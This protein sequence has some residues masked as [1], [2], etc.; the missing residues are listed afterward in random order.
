[1]TLAT[2]MAPTAI[3][4]LDDVFSIQT[5]VLLT[6]ASFVCWFCLFQILKHGFTAFAEYFFTRPIPTDKVW[7]PSALPHPNPPG[8]AVPFGIR[9]V[10]ASEEQIFRFM[11]F[12]GQDISVADLQE[13]ATASA[14]YKGKLYESKVLE[15]IDQHF[16]LKLP[17]LSYPYVAP[18]FNGFA[19]FWLE[20]GHHLRKMFV[21]SM[22]LSFEHAINGAILPI[23][24]LRTREIA[25]FNL[26]LISECGFQIVLIYHILLS[27][28]LRIDVTVEQMHRAVWPLL[29]VHHICTLAFCVMCLYLGDDCPR[30]EVSHLFIA[31]LGFTSTLHYI[32]Q[33]LDFSPLSQSNTPLIRMA[34]HVF[35]LG[36]QLYYRGLKFVVMTHLTMGKLYKVG[37]L[38]LSL[39]CGLIAL[40]F[41]AFN[42]D[43]IKFH[44]KATIGCAKKMTTSAA[45]TENEVDKIK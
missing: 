19:S 9:L 4:I 12:V 16:R 18:H 13:V 2:T 17:N 39:G 14:R 43:F 7:I 6:T 5:I 26:A 31:L 22:V 44:L 36:S 3:S 41:S 35:C 25:W 30:D 32:S 1:M 33:M 28:R 20:T 11:S 27:F 8:S 23:I 24:Y 37:G 21:A 10:D 15:W 34:N 42:I 29:L 45:A 40:L 38:P